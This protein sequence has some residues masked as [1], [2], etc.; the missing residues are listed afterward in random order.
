M[1]AGRIP[2]EGKE[3]MNKMTDGGIS[4]KK[5][6]VVGLGMVGVAFM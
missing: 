2:K 3:G 4:R 1:Q 5:V 6:V